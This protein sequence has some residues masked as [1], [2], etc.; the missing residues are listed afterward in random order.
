MAI[1]IC[2]I[3]MWM[4]LNLM[5]FEYMADFE[6]NNGLDESRVWAWAVYDGANYTLG[7]DIKDFMQWCF[8]RRNSC[9][10]WF[11]NLK[12][13]GEFII[14]YL[15]NNGFVW[16]KSAKTYKE[17]STLITDTNVFYNIKLI[18][19]NGKP[20]YFYDSFKLLAMSEA[21]IAETLHL[22]VQKGC[23]DY[24]TIRPVGYKPTKEEWSYIKDDV[25]IG[26]NGLKI[27]KEAKLNK[28]T[29]AS[30]AMEDFKSHGDTNFIKK[31]L[32]PLSIEQDA[33]IRKSYKGGFTYVNPIYKNKDIFKSGIVLDVNSLY[34][35]VM[36]TK[37]LPY[38]PPVKYK[39]KYFENKSFSLYIQC[40]R[41]NFEIKPNRVPTLQIKNGYFNPTEYLTSS[42][43][44]PQLLL[45]TNVDLK[46]FLEQYNVYNLEY[47]YGYMFKGE[48][49]IFEEYITRWAKNK[50]E[51]KKE[52]NY[53]MYQISK[54]M[55]NSLYGKFGS[56]PV[57][58]DKYPY[59][60]EDGIVRYKCN[61][62]EVKPKFYLPL[63]CF[64]TSY[65]RAH[66]I[67]AAQENYSRFLY[68]DTDSLHL[69]GDDIPENIRCD[70]YE[71]GAW[72]LESRF[73]RARY[74]RSKTYIEYGYDLET[75]KRYKN[76]TCAGLPASCHKYVT[77][78]NFK[79]GKVYYGKLMRKKVKGGV[80][81]I[82]SEFR[83]RE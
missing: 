61:E 46:L 6:T 32:K 56:N 58:I 82:E 50:I 53:G 67:R 39:G 27:F 83:I 49:G 16:T 52:K 18:K 5:E 3:C 38:G 7:T 43:D 40:I 11:H 55:Q 14:D 30:N 72:K 73:T 47:L 80:S 77:W 1:L 48:H 25:Y 64:I 4:Y 8:T 22:P 75:G 45:L 2:I 65:A 36:K 79:P 44:E 12:H 13:D 15:L 76:V 71:L 59:L 10:V 66:T 34:P 19:K 69:L 26:Y 54:I 20:L 62:P 57:T 23:I 68:S 74:V 70:D 41:C 78:N 17:F 28:M 33:D 42:G 21:K 35:Y 24:N 81:L 9:R 31:F 51:A 37:L 63:A 60:D 29:I